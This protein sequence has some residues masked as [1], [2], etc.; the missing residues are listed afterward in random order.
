MAVAI[1]T[2]AGDVGV[3]LQPDI[4]MTDGSIFAFDFSDIRVWP[5]QAN[6][7][8]DTTFNNL[9]SG[10]GDAVVNS[11]GYTMVFNT[12]GFRFSVGGT[13]QRIDLPAAANMAAASGGMMVSCWIS[14][15]TQTQSS[16]S[17]VAGYFDPSDNTGPWGIYVQTNKF[18]FVVNSQVV[19]SMWTSDI[20]IDE[21]HQVVLL[22]AEID[23]VWSVRVY[24]DGVLTME[25]DAAFDTLQSPTGTTVPLIG[26]THNID[27][28]SGY[29]IGK[30]CRTLGWDVS[31]L[32]TSEIEN[33]VSLD[34]DEHSFVNP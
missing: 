5:D 32:S 31:G 28:T 13:D 6:A 19:G 16:K 25:E 23:G 4:A 11:D 15:E 18:Y 24:I 30:F 17:R 8:D 29:W 2:E 27:G 14:S 20:G 9:V 26:D 1:I 21:M 10:G 34:F 33:I 12:D 22:W 7:P 3:K